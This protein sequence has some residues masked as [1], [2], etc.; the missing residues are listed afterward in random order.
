MLKK[1]NHL[2]GYYESRIIVL[3]QSTE[4][5]LTLL[6]DLYGRDQLGQ[7]PTPEEIKQEALRQHEIEWRNNENELVTLFTLMHKEKTC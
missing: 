2:P 3:D 4:D 6:D 5:D 7:N 1:Y